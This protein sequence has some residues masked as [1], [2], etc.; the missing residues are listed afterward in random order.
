MPSFVGVANLADS[1]LALKHLVYDKE[2]ISLNQY[3]EAL[4]NDFED[5]R[6]LLSMIQNIVPSYGNNNKE[7]DLMV[8]EI[9][10]WIREYTA[11]N[12]TFR[13]DRFIPSLFCWIIHEKMGRET[14]A[15]P[16][17]RK[18]DSHLE[19]DQDQPRD[20]EQKDLLH[21]LC[22]QQAGTIK[23]SLVALLLI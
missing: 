23:N 14:G 17:G 21:Q 1:L 10:K 3:V 13:N 4:K 8:S 16:D 9:T 7:A 2:K 12:T 15:S 22:Q 18:G 11:L 20:V 19:M 5:N 6:L